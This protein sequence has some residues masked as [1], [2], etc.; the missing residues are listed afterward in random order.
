M[1][2]ENIRI[3]SE[4]LT[5]DTV[6]DTLNV[7]N[8][9]KYRTF[10]IVS[11]CVIKPTTETLTKKPYVVGNS[12]YQLVKPELVQSRKEI[13]VRDKSTSKVY[14]G[15]YGRSLLGLPPY[16]DV[17]VYPDKNVQFDIF[18]QSTSY[19]RKLDPESELIVM[20]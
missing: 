16:E 11:Q 15:E 2:T 1:K 13:L 19:T 6:T 10:P 9:S 4:E 8:P 14:G 17:K 7:I 18:I 5:I 20:I 3:N 12:Y